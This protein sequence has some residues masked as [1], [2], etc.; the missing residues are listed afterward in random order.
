MS[1]PIKE[2]LNADLGK[3][4]EEGSLRSQKIKEIFQAA[5]TESVGEIKNGSGEILTIL[6]DTTTV[7]V[8]YF[9]GKG[10][11]AQAD[12]MAA[13]EGAIAGINTD[14]TI[15]DSSELAKFQQQVQDEVNG[16]LVIVSQ[17]Q[18]NSSR[19]WK[20]LLLELFTAVKKR[21]L[22]TFNKEC[23]DLDRNLTEKYGDRYIK[24]KERW[25]TAQ[26]AYNA[27]K[28]N[29]GD[30]QTSPADQ[31]QTELNDQAAKAGATVAQ[32]EVM[33]RKQLKTILQTAAAKL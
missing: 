28:E 19:S 31:Q 32:A 14:T 33:A 11:Q 8:E 26:T 16:A 21:F 25:E 27:T 1:T 24:V 30:R 2:R 15:R 5:V 17:P 20:S 22:L 12:A 7:I 13:V 10:Q 3:V 4:K 29:M 9:K 23:A 18:E 6:K